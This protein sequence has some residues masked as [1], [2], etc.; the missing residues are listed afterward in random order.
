VSLFQ[1]NPALAGALADLDRPEGTALPEGERD[2]AELDA[3][4]RDQARAEQLRATT[5]A[6]RDEAER[7]GLQ[8]IMGAWESRVVVWR[9]LFDCHMLEPSFVIGAPD[10]TAFREGERAAGLRL[11]AALQRHAP[12]HYAQM[13]RENEAGLR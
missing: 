12:D 1:E 5:V 13:V 3:T 6:L 10:H 2:L 9:F 4:E 8:L 11:L 7:K